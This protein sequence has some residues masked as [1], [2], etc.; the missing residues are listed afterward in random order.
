VVFARGC[1]SRIVAEGLET[2]DDAARLQGL[3]V[4]YGQGWFFGRPGKA[5]AMRERYDVACEAAP[6]ALPSPRPPERSRI[7][8]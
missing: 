5:E 8:F 3:G 1:G 7:S 6:A 2:A 4:D